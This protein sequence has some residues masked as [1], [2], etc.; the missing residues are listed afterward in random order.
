MPIKQRP[1]RKN[2]VGDSDLTELESRFV[3]EYMIDLNAKR[4]YERAGGKDTK[5]SAACIMLQR[6]R[7][8]AA[9]NALKE[10][11]RRKMDIKAED[12]LNKLA[13][14]AFADRRG[15]VTDQGTAKALSEVPADLADAVEVEVYETKEKKYDGEEVV[16]ADVVVKK[17]KTADKLKAMELMCRMLG[18]MNDKSTVQHEFGALT[19]EQLRDRIKRLTGVA[20][21]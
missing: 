7:V 8:I 14:I 6:P 12:I 19:D 17:I 1:G 3:E 13:N 5:G 15:F 10:E 2:A 4:A 20:P 16:M 11:R 18:L 9:I 21:E